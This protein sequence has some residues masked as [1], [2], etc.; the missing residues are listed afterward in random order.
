MPVKRSAKKEMRKSRKRYQHNR[1]IL[2]AVKK[3]VKKVRATKTKAE[4]D[5]LYTAAIKILDRAAIKSIIHKN[6]AA[7][8][9]SRLA[10]LIQ[11]LEPKQTKTA[12]A[13]S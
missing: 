12:T 3:I 13:Q 9:K 2:T 11:K 10:K 8:L 1:A 6:K 4:A 5:P 7:R